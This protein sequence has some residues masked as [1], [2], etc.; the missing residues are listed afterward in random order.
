MGGSGE[1]VELVRSWI[2]EVSAP[3]MGM[4]F[5]DGLGEFAKCSSLVF[6][7][8]LFF[9]KF[10]FRFQGG[11]GIGGI[12]KC[13]KHAIRLW[14]TGVGVSI[15]RHFYR[16]RPPREGAHPDQLVF[17]SILVGGMKSKGTPGH[18]TP[19]SPMV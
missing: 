8:R 4:V 3:V 7:I 2:W 1:G 10:V 18:R 11:L 9:S 6:R 13:T 12:S 19:D 16:K 14:F 5:A 17:L 15:D